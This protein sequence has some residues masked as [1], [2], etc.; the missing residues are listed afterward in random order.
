MAKDRKLMEVHGVVE[1]NDDDVS[2]KLETTC[3]D[4]RR[5][6]TLA[7]RLKALRG[8][9]AV[10]ASIPSKKAQ[11]KQDMR[12]TTRIK[13]DAKGSADALASPEILRPRVRSRGG[14]S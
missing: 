3:D 7:E 2:L 11:P 4:T 5:C 12:G 6:D 8:P 9:G 1:V 14:S 13:K 10:T